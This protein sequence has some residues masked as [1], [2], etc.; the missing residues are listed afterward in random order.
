MSFKKGTDRLNDKNIR[1]KSKPLLLKQQ[2][3]LK[4]ITPQQ[5]T[6]VQPQALNSAHILSLQGMI[7][8]R[9]VQQLFP[10]ST[11]VVLQRKIPKYIID[12]IGE[13][14]ED[15]PQ[16]YLEQII[17]RV[18]TYHEIKNKKEALLYLDELE[19][20]IYLG[21]KIGS[22]VIT[23]TKQRLALYNLLDAIQKE[24]QDLIAKMAEKNEFP[25]YYKN[26][27][28]KQKQAQH[29]WQAIIEGEIFKF[30]DKISCY[31][32]AKQLPKDVLTA[33][34]SEIYADLARI[35]SRPKGLEL[36]DQLRQKVEDGK[37]ITIGIPSL[38]KLTGKSTHSQTD[39]YV[40]AK[41]SAST[42]NKAY[43]AS[44]M[45][46]GPG[47][48]AEL[49]IS[50]GVK[51]TSIM[52]Y[53]KYGKS[54]LS[55]HFVTLAHELIHANHYQRGMYA[56]TASSQ[57]K[58]PAGLKDYDYDAEEFMTIASKEER[59]KNIAEEVRIHTKQGDLTMKIGD[60]IQ[61]GAYPITEAD[62]REEHGLSIHRPWPC[63]NRKST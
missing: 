27:L 7:G 42:Q 20:F 25:E 9:A 45:K 21:F 15:K 6:P 63:F 40:G 35:M 53:D 46:A 41:A 16:L 23:S 43:M 28:Q 17:N 44:T 32:E 39:P 11:S 5:A 10:T 36:I 1:K 61:T 18:E 4:A 24:Y 62:I 51:D 54:I 3:N 22:P 30:N 26:D 56:A 29:L 2:D 8:N 33:F 14:K 59:A 50:P 60:L 12:N 49:E 19:K 52:D 58:G 13:A 57:Q 31:G 37:A 34:K 48:S 47:S 38:G 55:P